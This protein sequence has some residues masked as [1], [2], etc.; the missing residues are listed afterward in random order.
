VASASACGEALF[1]D[2]FIDHLY[3]FHRKLDPS[4]NRAVI[5]QSYHNRPDKKENILAPVDRQCEWLRQLG[6]E[7]GDCFFKVFELALIGGRRRPRT[8]P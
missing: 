2:F 5:A 3:R 8:M 7:D 1:D 6:F 4:S